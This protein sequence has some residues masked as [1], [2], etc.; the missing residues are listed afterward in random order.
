MIRLVSANTDAPTHRRTLVSPVGAIEL[1]G[2][3]DV[4]TGLVI[5]AKEGAA[6]DPTW[7]AAPSAFAE[8]CEQLAD[9]FAG[10]R[11]DFDVA[12]D[13]GGTP[14]Q[15]TVWTALLEIPSGHTTNYGRLAA[16][17]GNPKAVRAVGAAN[18]RNPIPILI[19]CHRVI[20]ANGDLIGYGGGLHVKARL[21]ALEGASHGGQSQL[22]F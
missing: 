9:Y 3:G 21:L 10:Q 22:W 7:L 6:A 1:I 14:F 13:P 18:G 17:I 5:D 4:L 20:G 2:R 8:V 19:P 12:V 15:R 11:T 16:A